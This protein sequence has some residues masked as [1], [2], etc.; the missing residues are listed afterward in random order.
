MH[1]LCDTVR[2]LGCFSPATE[3]TEDTE[4][5]AKEESSFH[6][7]FVGN[8]SCPRY[9][10]LKFNKLKKNFLILLKFLAFQPT[11]H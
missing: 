5:I 2:L 6:A 4:F 11:F 3:I 10:F 9:K 8:V 1:S 7:L